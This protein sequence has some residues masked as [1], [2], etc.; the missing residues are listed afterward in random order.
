MNINAYIIAMLCY[1]FVKVLIG[2]YNYRKYCNNDNGKTV[3]DEESFYDSIY[4]LVSAAG[5]FEC[6]VFALFFKLFF[7]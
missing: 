5:V 6:V 3:N 1:C 7:T 4:W 2:L